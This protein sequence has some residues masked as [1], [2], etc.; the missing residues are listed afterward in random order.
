M[1]R[2]AFRLVRSSTPGSEAPVGA[3]ALLATDAWRVRAALESA[4]RHGRALED[5]DAVA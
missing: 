3:V 2:D 5:F 1:E 4:A